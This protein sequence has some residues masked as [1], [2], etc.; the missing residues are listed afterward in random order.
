MSS[1]KPNRIDPEDGGGRFKLTQGISEV[2]RG[3]YSRISLYR[4]ENEGLHVGSHSPTLGRHGEPFAK[5][6]SSGEGS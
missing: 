6:G 1:D 5:P 2:S 4:G 3:D